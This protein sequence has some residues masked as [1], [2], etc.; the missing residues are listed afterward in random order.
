ME[1]V[2]LSFWTF[3]FKSKKELKTKKRLFVVAYEKSKLVT[4]IIWIVFL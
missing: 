3:V 4:T 1:L 2:C